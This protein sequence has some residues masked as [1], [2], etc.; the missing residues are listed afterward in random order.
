MSNTCDPVFLCNHIDN[1]NNVKKSLQDQAIKGSNGNYT[2]DCGGFG[3]CDA[4]YNALATK[5][6]PFNTYM[7]GKTLT[8]DDYIK[9]IKYNLAQIS[10]GLIK[11]SA[12]LITS[13]FGT[14]E[15]FQ[16]YVVNY[17]SSVQLFAY[18]LSLFVVIAVFGYNAY[19][20]IM[21][22]Y[23]AVPF[24]Y[25]II[26]LIIFVIIT[27][28]ILVYIYIYTFNLNVSL[29]LPPRSKNVGSP[30][31]YIQY[32]KA[33]GISVD[34]LGDRP[35]NMLL[36]SFG[37]FAILAVLIPFAYFESKLTNPIVNAITKPFIVLLLIGLMSYITAYNI[38]YAMFMPELILLILII[39]WMYL[40]VN[41][42]TLNPNVF[43]FTNIIIGI[44]IAVF[45]G[46]LFY[47]FAYN[48]IPPITPSEAS[49]K[50]NDTTSDKNYIYALFFIFAILS[51]IGMSLIVRGT[52]LTDYP[53]Y[54]ISIFNYFLQRL[55]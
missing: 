36:I 51:L 1:I 55:I 34:N 49:C 52:V 14:I 46:Y 28:V 16:K 2:F 8:S 27:L 7:S 47:E 4:L 30:D 33:Q 39:Q 21:A 38:Y 26:G 29:Q 32:F 45:V 6:T 41:K 15:W 9:Q 3:D 53:T 20:I 23:S 17:Q 42:T 19:Q 35:F 5:Q 54:M 12:R 22:F 40:V 11:K 31:E 13:E 43:K 25:L 37:F 24:K 44:V 10:D 50:S 18:I 48:T